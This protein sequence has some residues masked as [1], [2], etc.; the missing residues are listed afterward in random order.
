M[1]DSTNSKPPVQGIVKAILDTGVVLN[2]LTGGQC[3]LPIEKLFGYSQEERYNRYD[4]IYIGERIEV[5]LSNSDNRRKMASE[6]QA[7]EQRAERD[8]QP[9]MDV[10]FFVSGENAHGICARLISPEYARG[11]HAFFPK[12]RLS[13][14]FFSLL[15][16]DLTF[17]PEER[18][19]RHA[20]IAHLGRDGKNRLSIHLA[21]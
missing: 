6:M 3:F 2:L 9:H 16:D 11:Q 20:H 1:T 4:A 17:N 12:H 13:D 14:D 15:E 5:I 19:G 18:V 10:E 7:R 21:E 8:L